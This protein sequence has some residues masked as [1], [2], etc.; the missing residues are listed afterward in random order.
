MSRD[1]GSQR[2][3]PGTAAATSFCRIRRTRKAVLRELALAVAA[4]TEARTGRV[5]NTPGVAHLADQRLRPRR[6]GSRQPER[7][8]LW[9]QLDVIG[10]LVV[11]LESAASA[12]GRSPVDGVVLADRL[13]A[14]SEAL[15]R[16]GQALSRSPGQHRPSDAPRDDE[17]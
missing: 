12:P 17:R 10:Q 3:A 15:G 5:G 16:A 14:A 8:G 9:E 13:G 2:N 6:P 11:D 7:P 4:L 1:A